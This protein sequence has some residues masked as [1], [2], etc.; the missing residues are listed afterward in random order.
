MNKNK[1]LFDDKSAQRDDNRD[2]ITG[3]PGAHPVGTGIGAAATGAAAGAGAGAIAGPAGAAIGAVAG[4]IAGGLAGKAIAEKVNPTA[5]DAYWRENFTKR[6]YA[7]PAAAYDDY[8]PAYRHGWE[9]FERYGRKGRTFDNAESDLRGSWESVKGKSRLGWDRAKEATRD[10]WNRI[11]R[12]IPG[13]S[14][15]D[16]N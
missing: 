16:G 4:G 11:E 10:A 6:P 2:P 7:G 3:A 8:A 15:G 1:D 13:D 9:G 5:E 14:D 12:A